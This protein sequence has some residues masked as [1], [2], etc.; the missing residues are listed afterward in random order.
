MTTC[1]NLSDFYNQYNEYKSN[2][3]HNLAYVSNQNN[4]S[5]KNNFH[6]K[7]YCGIIYV[8]RKSQ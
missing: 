5:C 3:K 8:R 2:Y 4:K 7:Y 1:D 6:Y